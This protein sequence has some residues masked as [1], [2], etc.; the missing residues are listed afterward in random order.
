MSEFAII[1]RNTSSLMIRYR[2]FIFLLVA[3]GCVFFLLGRYVSTQDRIITEKIEVD[4]GVHW[5]TIFGGL[6]S[7]II[8][9]RS[10]VLDTGYSDNHHM[11]LSHRNDPC[12]YIKEYVPSPYEEEQFSLA[13]RFDSI[14]NNNARR[15][16]LTDYLSSDKNVNQSFQWTN[17]VADRMKYPLKYS[18]RDP[19]DIDVMY[20]SRF[21][22]TRQCPQHPAVTWIEWIEPLTVHARHPFSLLEQ[23]R[24]PDRMRTEALGNIS[25]QFTKAIAKSGFSAIINQVNLINV[26]HILVHHRGISGSDHENDA[27]RN[28][29]SHHSKPSLQKQPP[30]TTNQQ[31]GRNYMF[32]AG[33]SGFESS[34]WWF[35]CMY[36]LRNISFDQI[37]GWEMTLLQPDAFWEKVPAPIRSRYHFFNAPVSSNISHG[38]SVLRMIL[39]TSLP[40]DY[41][42][43]KLD[44]DTPHVEIP[45]ALDILTNPEVR[46][47]VD[48]FFFEFHFRCDIMMYCGWSDNIPMTQYGLNLSSRYDAMDLFRRYRRKGI[49]SHFWP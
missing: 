23:L 9:D 41:V 47:L 44:I 31:S 35:T 13:R 45:I 15:K 14:N 5:G 3:W 7:W 33:T 39:E 10:C 30:P 8:G 19:D 28:I 34:L 48:E 40:H 25:H 16:A 43:F 36:K 32:D 2:W 20:L 18:N 49:R 24:L 17:R 37:F 22:I 11:I 12:T 46:N 21:N 1:R 29:Q 4:R 6:N 26:D 38:N 27:T 42:A